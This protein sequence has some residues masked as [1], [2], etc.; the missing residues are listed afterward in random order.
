MSFAEMKKKFILEPEKKFLHISDRYTLPEG[1]VNIDRPD[2]EGGRVYVNPSMPGDE[3]F[4]TT[5][6]LGK[7]AKMKG[8]DKWL[9]AW[10]E[11]IGEEAADKITNDA[12]RR[13]THMHQMLEDYLCN[14]PVINRHIRGYSLFEKIKPWCDNRIDAVVACEHAL[15]SRRLKIAGRVDL[16]AILDGGGD[17]EEGIETLVDFKSSRKIKKREDI[18]GYFRQVT[19]YGMMFEETTNHRLELGEIWMGCDN[20]GKPVAKNFEVVFGD[21]KETVIDEVG[22]FWDAVGQPIDRDECKRFFL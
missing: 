21:Y 15:F 18:G 11:Q 20:N 12:L 10:R 16:V 19:I 3:F 7:I 2:E 14:R 1:W 22:D 5:N 17:P 9:E 6:I 13:G 4:S 8:E